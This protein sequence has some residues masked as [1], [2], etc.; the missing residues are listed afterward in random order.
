MVK[1]KT[2]N[3]PIPKPHTP[4]TTAAA[5]S[6]LSALSASAESSRTR[7]YTE[8]RVYTLDPANSKLPKKSTYLV[9]N[10]VR[11]N[12]SLADMDRL[13]SQLANITLLTGI[14]KL[15]DAPMAW[16]E[17]VDTF[18]KTPAKTEPQQAK[19]SNRPV[20]A[21]APMPGPIPG[22]TAPK[23]QPEIPTMANPFKSLIKK[24][25]IKAPEEDQ[26]SRKDLIINSGIK[27]SS[28]QIMQIFSHG[29]PAHSSYACWHCCHTFNTTPVGIPLL[30]V[31]ME[32]HCY[33]N[34][35]SYNCAKRYLRPNA[36]DLTLME[37]TDTL[38]NDDIGEQM[39]LLELLCHIETGSPIDQPIKPAPPRLSLIMF[40]GDKTIEA[41]RNNANCNTCYHIFRSPMVP[42]S[43]QMEESM[44][45]VGRKRNQRVSL[46]T[47]KIQRA[48]NELNEKS[49]AATLSK[50]MVK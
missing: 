27:R 1:S 4:K 14:E 43:Y 21:A 17:S 10:M 34:F 48:F 15:R 13:E 33:G 3:D 40:G 45:K 28:T 24:P 12:I 49:K 5:A 18:Y 19:T 38:I 7:S 6:A 29:W 22:G 32:F 41:F 39:Q 11:L 30:M 47:V 36:E 42:I 26:T 9:N 2:P 16:N 37:L 50:R 46:D 20:T 44:D 35:C 25:V 31:N 23:L 8:T